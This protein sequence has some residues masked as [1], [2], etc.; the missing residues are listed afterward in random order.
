M[1]HKAALI[2]L[3]AV[4]KLPAGG[5]Y[6][7]ASGL[8]D[9][10]KLKREAKFLQMRGYAKIRDDE[11]F[12]EVVGQLSPSNGY[13][14]LRMAESYMLM[15]KFAKA[16]EYLKLSHGTGHPDK[17]FS[18]ELIRMYAAT[19]ARAVNNDKLALEIL[20]PVVSRPYNSKRDLQWK[21][22]HRILKKLKKIIEK[23]KV[24]PEYKYKYYSSGL[25]KSVCRGF[26]GD[27]TVGVFI[28]KRKHIK[29]SFKKKPYIPILQ[30]SR[31]YVMR[32]KES[33]PW[34]ANRIIAKRIQDKKRM[35]IDAVTGATV[36]SCAIIVGA[37]E[38][39]Q[40]C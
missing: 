31:V 21:N 1:K 22:A 24:Q 38:A 10:G 40:S 3:E 36:T 28:T 25:Y 39:M 19:M 27:I 8:T 7:A 6:E 18:D 9:L 17:K 13:E 23:E 30:L 20:E 15:E 12:K 35:L 37:E 34:S 4:Q 16:E 29:N 26:N 2:I 33:H 32:E 14:N 11:Q 5:P